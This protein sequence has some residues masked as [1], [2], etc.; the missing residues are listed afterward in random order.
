MI[1][2]RSVYARFSWDM[3]TRVSYFY[4]CWPNTTLTSNKCNR[5]HDLRMVTTN[6]KSNVS[7]KVRSWDVVYTEQDIPTHTCAQLWLHMVKLDWSHLDYYYSCTSCSNTQEEAKED[8]MK[9]GFNK[10]HLTVE[11]TQ[12][13][14]TLGVEWQNGTDARSPVLL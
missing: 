1:Y 13:F 3:F 5:S 8:Q 9:T 10:W 14:H 2:L 7:W 11:I 12:D 4:L 6:T